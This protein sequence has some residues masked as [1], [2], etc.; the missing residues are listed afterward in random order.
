M[1]ILRE[2][3]KADKKLLVAIN[4]ELTELKNIPL[5]Y[6]KEPKKDEEQG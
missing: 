5:F 2:K 4:M 1:Q 3:V 6:E